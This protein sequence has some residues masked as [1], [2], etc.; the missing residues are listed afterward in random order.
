MLSGSFFGAFFGA[1]YPGPDGNF[2]IL[3]KAAEDIMPYWNG[4]ITSGFTLTAGTGEDWHQMM[5]NRAGTSDHWV[6]FD[7]ASGRGS[8]QHGDESAPL[9]NQRTYWV[10]FELS[11][12][13]TV[14]AILQPGVKSAGSGT[15]QLRVNGRVYEYTYDG[16]VIT[17]TLKKGTNELCLSMDSAPD[18]IQ[19]S[20]HLWGPPG[21]SNRWVPPKEPR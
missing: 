17:I 13:R 9:S 6:P 8:L 2:K 16:Q 20:C 12:P 21:D 14:T 3:G 7:V 19:L 11:Q 5:L 1:G 10:S 18:S 4:L 15:Y